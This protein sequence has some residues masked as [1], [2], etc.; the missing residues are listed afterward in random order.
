MH[1]ICDKNC[2]LEKFGRIEKTLAPKKLHQVL[3]CSMVGWSPEFGTSSQL[4]WR[5]LWLD[6]LSP[7]VMAQS[8]FG[9]WPP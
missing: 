7:E 4:C 8:L 5:R 2:S 1:E 9:C 3:H 6:I